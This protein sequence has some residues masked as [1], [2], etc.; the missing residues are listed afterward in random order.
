MEMQVVNESI[1]RNLVTPPHYLASHFFSIAMQE[2]FQ[3]KEGAWTERPAYGDISLD[4]D[5]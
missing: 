4:N 5:E 1:H 3:D 2:Y